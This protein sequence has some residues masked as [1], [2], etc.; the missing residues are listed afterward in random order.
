MNCLSWSFRLSAISSG[1]VAVEAVAGYLLSIP[2][3]AQ[4]AEGGD[5]G[6]RSLR[7]CLCLR[8]AHLKQVAVGIQDLDQADDAALIG[9]SRVLARTGQRRFTSRQDAGLGLAFDEGGEGVLD[10]LGR[11]QDGQ[12]VRG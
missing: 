7:L 8:V 10:V 6:A 5:G 9:G 3:A 11:A 2:S 1:E 4:G 12:A